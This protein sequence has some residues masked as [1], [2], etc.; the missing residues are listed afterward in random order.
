[1]NDGF[2]PDPVFGCAL[3]LKVEV[4]GEAC[5]LSVLFRADDVTIVRVGRASHASR[6]SCDMLSFDF[7]FKL[8][9]FALTFSLRAESACVLSK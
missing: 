2:S 4:G 5:V 9:I 8:S 7:V 6:N 3:F 1:M